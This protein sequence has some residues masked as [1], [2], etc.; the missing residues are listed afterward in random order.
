MHEIREA[1]EKLQMNHLSDLT[2]RVI[3]SQTDK[4]NVQKKNLSGNFMPLNLSD[5]LEA[6]AKSRH[7]S[8]LKLK[9]PSTLF[10]KNDSGNIAQTKPMKISQPKVQKLSED[11]EKKTVKRVNSA[12][13]EFLSNGLLK[14]YLK[15]LNEVKVWSSSICS[16]VVEINIDRGQKYVD[17]L[18]IGL[19][20]LLQHQILLSQDVFL[21]GI[22]K[23]IGSLDDIILDIPRINELLADLLLELIRDYALSISS[24]LQTVEPSARIAEQIIYKIC[25]DSDNYWY[26]NGDDLLKDAAFGRINMRYIDRVI[27]ISYLS[28]N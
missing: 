15:E 9:I 2:M 27:K 20:Y 16:R 23:L 10:T 24:V 11:E 18:L 12:I 1:A 21:E 25:T 4:A 17:C 8:D 3:K 28:F 19:K 14:N 22:G 13:I 7:F 6:G 26:L 5:G